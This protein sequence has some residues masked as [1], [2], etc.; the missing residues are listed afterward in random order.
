MTGAEMRSFAIG[1]LSELSGVKIPTIRY[2]EMNG[3][4]PAAV[5]TNTNRRTYDDTTVRRLIFIRHA[6]QLGFEVDAIRS[7]LDLAGRS[8]RSSTDD[9]AIARR[10]VADIDER[11]VRLTA[12]RTEVQAVVD[13]NRQGRAAECRIIEVLT[14]HERDVQAEP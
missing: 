5:R 14:D 2:Y 7:L 3:L 11:L 13:G 12:L 1:T 10:H 9:A 6:R 8:D 4:L